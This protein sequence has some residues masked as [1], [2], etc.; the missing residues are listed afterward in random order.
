MAH[1]QC[2]SAL[3]GP[4]RLNAELK[5]LHYVINFPVSQDAE[6]Q[7]D[8]KTFT[9]CMQVQ[10]VNEDPLHLCHTGSSVPHAV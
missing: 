9:A 7:V 4:V 6:W 5:Q 1:E 8:L 2:S 10:H 3:C